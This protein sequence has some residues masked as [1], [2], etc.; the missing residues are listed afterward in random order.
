MFLEPPVNTPGYWILRNAFN[1]IKSFGVFVCENKK[2]NNRWKSAHAYKIYRQGCKSCDQYTLPTYMWVNENTH[3]RD[4][5]AIKDTD[6]PHDSERCE[7]CKVGV[8]IICNGIYTQ[9]VEIM[10]EPEPDVTVARINPKPS[11]SIYTNRQP[12]ITRD[13]LEIRRNLLREKI[14]KSFL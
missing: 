6:K 10:M 5:D 8:C 4:N 11:Q 2:C 14:K 3:I 13:D 9:S 7:A 1:G 12:S